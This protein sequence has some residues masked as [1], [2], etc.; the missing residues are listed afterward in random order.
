MKRQNSIEE[1]VRSLKA[2]PGLGRQVVFHKK[3]P[4]TEA[5]FNSPARPW[6]DEMQ[7][8]LE[9]SGISGLYSHQVLAIDLVRSGQ[10]VVVST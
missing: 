7:V 9:G 2:S 8:L 3:L 5:C 4:P 6:S 1:Y 10:H